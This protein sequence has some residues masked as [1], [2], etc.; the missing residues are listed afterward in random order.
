MVNLTY[1]HNWGIKILYI[2]YFDKFSNVDLFKK[3]YYKHIT[4]LSC[5]LPTPLAV[6]IFKITGSNFI[7][8]IRRAEKP[9]DNKLIPKS[10]RPKSTSIIK[11]EKMK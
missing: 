7:G 6:K 11:I 10:I 3:L 1:K 4:K 5:Y 9:N 2:R 8:T